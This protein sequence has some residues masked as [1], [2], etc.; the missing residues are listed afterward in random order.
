MKTHRKKLC[1]TTHM[2]G[3]DRWPVVLRPARRVR[4]HQHHLRLGHPEGVGGRA[5]VPAR[6]EG[7]ARA[8]KV[9]RVALR[10]DAVLRNARVL[11]YNFM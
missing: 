2:Y 6:A 8:D 10:H 4:G 9:Q 11:N 3:E 7:R 5:V 1:V